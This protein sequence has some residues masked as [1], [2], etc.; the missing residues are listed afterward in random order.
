MG[1]RGEIIVKGQNTTQNA[2]LTAI[3]G[4]NLITTIGST[5]QFN[6]AGIDSDGVIVK[7][8]WDFD[9]DGVFEYSS[10]EDGRTTNIYNKVGIYEATLRIT[11][12]D[13]NTANNSRIINVQEEN[14]DST[15]DDDEDESLL[16]SIS[17]ISSIAAIGI[18]ALRRRY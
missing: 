2:T 14:D 6:G 17:L 18:I 12:N 3:V 11:D 13:G 15:E 10:K 9:G 5:I 8:E 16:P 7:Y 1:M 4:E